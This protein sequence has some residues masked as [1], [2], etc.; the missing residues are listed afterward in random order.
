MKHVSLNNVLCRHGNQIGSIC[1]GCHGN[2]AAQAKK[3]KRKQPINISPLES[4]LVAPA[5][6]KAKQIDALLKEQSDEI[7]RL[8]G[9]KPKKLT[10]KQQAQVLVDEV[11]AALNAYSKFCGLTFRGYNAPKAGG[12]SKVAAT[13]HGNKRLTTGRQPATVLA[14]GNAGQRRLELA[15]RFDGVGFQSPFY[16]KH[17]I[18]CTVKLHFE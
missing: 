18:Y 17:P 9:A 8:R 16:L 2:V 11:A 14:S 3:P 10:H 1:F 5:V 7:S 4:S 6:A 15:G 13:P 12:D